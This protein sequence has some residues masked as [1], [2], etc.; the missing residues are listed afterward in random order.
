MYLPNRETELNKVDK[1]VR[2]AIESGIYVIVDWHID[3]AGALPLQS[4]A[5]AFFEQMAQQWGSYPNVLFEPWNEPLD[6]DS[7]WTIKAYHEVLVPAIRQHTQNIIILGSRSWSQDVDEPAANPVRGTNL[8]YALHFYAITHRNSY[9]AKAQVAVNAGLAL[10]ASEWGVCAW[11]GGTD[12]EVDWWEVK[13]WTDFFDANMISHTV[14]SLHD[15]SAQAEDPSKVEAC[16]L[17]HPSASTEGNWDPSH[18]SIT[19]HA[20]KAYIKGEQY[21]SNGQPISPGQTVAAPA[22]V[23]TTAVSTCHSIMSNTPDSWCKTSC[24]HTPPFCPET[25]CQGCL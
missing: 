1:V 20:M 4:E 17:V 10:F 9:R 19:G 2:A 5:K 22:H 24:W 7:W 18:L 6:T 12:W 3:D 21:L 13:R 25:V 23:E 14:W 16:S 11:Y 8:A 15:N